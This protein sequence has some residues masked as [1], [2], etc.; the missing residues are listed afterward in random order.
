MT[1][2]PQP[3][4]WF[5]VLVDREDLTAA[6]DV[7]ARSARVELESHGETAVPVLAPESG[8][9]L[10][11]FADLEQRCAGFWPPPQAHEPDER[12][13]PQVMLKHAMERL[14]SWVAD[15]SKPIEALEHRRR[16]YAELELLNTLFRE[17]GP[18]LPNLAELSKAGPMLKTRLFA[19][20]D[21]AWPETLP[22]NSITRRIATPQ[23]VFLLAVGLPADI[24]ELEIRLKAQKARPVALP[25]DLP[26]SIEA[27]ATVIAERLDAA[28]SAIDDAENAIRALNEEHD[29][30]DAVADARFVRWYVD[31]IPVLASTEHFAWITGWTSDPNEEDLLG[32]LAAADIRGL[33]R[34]TEP[35]P[36]FEPPLLLRN[37]PWMRPFEI[38][39]RMLGVPAASEADPTRI[40]AIASP[41]MFGY[42]FGDVGQGAVL[43]LAGILLRKRFPILRLLIAAGA[44]SI[45]FGA[46]FGS[47]F[48]LEDFLPALWLR[49]IDAPITIIIIPLIGGAMLLLIGMC[50]DAAQ[51]YWQRRARGWWQSGAGLMLCYL[52]LLAALWQPALL[53]IAALGG[54]WFVIG[55]AL[56]SH[57]KRLAAAG[58]ALAE[59]IESVLQL[60]VNTV[61]FVR[62]GAFALAHSGLSLAVVGV[63]GASESTVL[64]VLILVIGNVLIIGLEGLVVAIQTTRL[65]LF[66]FFVR[67]LHA[68]GRPFRPMEPVGKPVSHQ[69]GRS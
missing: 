60:V 58:S 12:E 14:R 18:S 61:S 19:L 66:E 34:L 48:S 52:S 50:L 10:N 17:S 31:N 3:A 46:L 4:A 47:V 24:D 42:M 36:G 67:F 29:V 63:A 40:V 27:A 13:E 57:G 26:E 25:A 54:G 55:H 11:E 16:A 7:L 30:A 33:L 2:R 56:T 8:V 1:L 68:E 43:L 64:Y 38:F 5:E 69:Y 22:E 9:L 37:P 39:T 35:P 41:L 59:F 21:D 53:W 62:V 32:R 49:P 45:I 28:N 44:V 51:A 20:A 23:L 65:V 15:A 6:L